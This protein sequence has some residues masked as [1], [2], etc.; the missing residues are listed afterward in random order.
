MEDQSVEKIEIDLL[1]D[2]LYRRYGYDFRHYA[3]ASIRRRVLHL[4][5]K[6]SCQRISDLIPR[7]LHDEAFSAAVINDLTITVTDMFRDPTFYW[8]V[9]QAVFPYLST[10]PFFKA[11]VAGCATGEEVYSLAILLSE[12]GLYD[13][14]TL[15]GTDV[16][17][18]ALQKAR[19]GIF[20]LKN[21]QRYTANYQQAGGM[22]SFANYY[23]ARYQSA[24]MDQAL[25]SNITFASHNLVTDGVFSEVHLIFCRNVLIYFDRSLQSRVL[26]ILA[27][28]LCRGGFLCLGMKETIEFSGVQDRFQVVDA[29]A[30]IYQ[31]GAA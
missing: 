15:F 25:K 3:Q 28:S 23:H 5:A 8:A 13:R 27:D 18:T 24:I 21:I 26:E 4:L 2:A 7:L 14:A 1:L 29:R 22:R 6:S 10:Y 12:E 11:W 16:N 17:D 20:D 9:R 19:E 31:K 30:K